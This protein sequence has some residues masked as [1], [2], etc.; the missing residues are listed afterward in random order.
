MPFSAP[1]GQTV[2][3]VVR[4]PL[5]FCCWGRLLWRYDFFPSRFPAFFVPSCVAGF[6]PCTSASFVSFCIASLM[7]R[8]LTS[9]VCAALQAYANPDPASSCK[10]KINPEEKSENVEA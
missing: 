10:D 8:L 4:A 5:R 9:L 1:G 3:N 7:L 6:V 2:H